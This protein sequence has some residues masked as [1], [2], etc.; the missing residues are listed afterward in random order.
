MKDGQGEYI[1]CLKEEKVCYTER[2]AGIIINE[3]RRHHFNCDDKRGKRI[4]KRKYFCRACGFYH[5]T[6]YT[7]YVDSHKENCLEQKFYASLAL[8]NILHPLSGIQERS[9]YGKADIF[10]E[11]QDEIDPPDGEMQEVSG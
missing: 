10:F 7:F 3:A 4:P 11:R 5:V 1:R 9:A 6:H 2:E 8:P